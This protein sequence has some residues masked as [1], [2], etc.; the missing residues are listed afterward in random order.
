MPAATDAEFAFRAHI[1]GRGTTG[2]RGYDGLFPRIA[3]RSSPVA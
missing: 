1:D 2:C 3:F